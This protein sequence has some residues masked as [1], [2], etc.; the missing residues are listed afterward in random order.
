VN[1]PETIQL[2]SRDDGLRTIILDRP[3]RRNAFNDQMLGELAAAVVDVNSDVKSKVLVLRG[4][5]KAFCAGRDLDELADVSARESRMAMPPP[6][7]HESGM[8]RT[9][10]VPTIAVAEGA[11]VGG[12][13]G[14][15]LQCDVKLV[16]EN[17]LLL[18]GHLRNGMISSVP[19]FYLP[20]LTSMAN[21]LELLCSPAGVSGARAAEMGVVDLAVPADEVEATL[22][23]LVASLVQW[24]SELLRHTIR[25]LRHARADSYESTMSM[26]G[27]LRTMR[28]RKGA[29][30]TH[31]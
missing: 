17:A 25:V 11:A 21:S 8:F 31:G 28:R 15:L 6:G 5:R 16:A 10:E 7:G 30:S 20:R 3:E 4:S 19:S 12:G 14:F 26:V 13:L 22:E 23:E 24:D 2:Q 18:D 27:F 29:G 9:L 1:A